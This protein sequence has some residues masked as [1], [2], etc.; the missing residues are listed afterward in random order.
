MVIKCVLRKDVFALICCS[1]FDYSEEFFYFYFFFVCFLFYF[2][3]VFLWKKM[4]D[5]EAV[6]FC[7]VPQSNDFSLTQ[8][9]VPGMAKFEPQQTLVKLN[10]FKV[11][12]APLHVVMVHQGR[13]FIP[14]VFFFW[15]LFFLLIL[16]FFFISF[17]IFFFF[18]F[19]L[20]RSFPHPRQKN[21]LHFYFI[22]LFISSFLKKSFSLPHSPKKRL[23]KNASVPSGTESQQ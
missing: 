22:F 8:S 18:S 19:S 9:F 5:R 21:E 3:F 23:S 17:F 13:G 16:D 14:E 11:F 1:I 15:S 4:A 2:S 10:I 7:S 12:G 6:P 20:K